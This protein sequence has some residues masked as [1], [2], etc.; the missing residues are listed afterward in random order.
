LQLKSSPYDLAVIDNDFDS[1]ASRRRMVDALRVKPDGAR[2]VVLSYLSIGEAESFRSYWQA[3]WLKQKPAWLD[4]ENPDWDRNYLVQ[5]WDPAWQSLMLGNPGA[6]L[7]RIL[8]AGF[9]GVYLDGVDKFEKWARRGR[10][11]AA[12]DM[13][14]FIDKIGAYARAKHPGF[15]IFPQNGDRLLENG[16]FLDL[17]DGFGRED[18]ISG[19]HDDDVRNSPGSIRGSVRRLKT[20]TAAGKPVLVVEY[21]QKPERAAPMLD[22][23]RS[24]G[25][26]GYVTERKLKTL[27][28]PTI[29]CGSAN[30]LP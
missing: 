26:I 5:Y 18:L 8:D 15:L 3:S 11:S 13:I 16:G 9:D 19:E 24:Y 23:I 20:V 28:P 27:S 4:E 29:G 25:F 14:D 30:C 7:D 17:I 2:R 1:P 6:S 22:E 10:E 21:T 12:R